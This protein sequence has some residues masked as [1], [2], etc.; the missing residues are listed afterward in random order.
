MECIVEN[1]KNQDHQGAGNFFHAVYAESSFPPTL[2][3]ICIPCWKTLRGMNIEKH[4]QLY[5][6]VMRATTGG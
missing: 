2:M 6:N 1:C 3:W 5:R 4:S